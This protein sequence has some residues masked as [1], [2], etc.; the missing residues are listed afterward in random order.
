[1]CPNL[2]TAG[3]R[4]TRTVPV[5]TGYLCVY[6]YSHATYINACI[7]SIHHTATHRTILH[8]ITPCHTP[9]PIRIPIP[10]PMPIP[11]QP[12]QIYDMP[13]H[14]MPCHSVPMPTPMPCFPYTHTYVY[15]PTHAFAVL[16]LTR[17]LRGSRGTQTPATQEQSLRPLCPRRGC[18][19]SFH[20]RR[21]QF[22]NC[23]VPEGAVA[24]VPWLLSPRNSQGRG[25]LW[26]RYVTSVCCSG[27]VLAIDFQYV[28][29]QLQ[30]GGPDCT[31]MRGTGR[32]QLVFTI[33]M[34]QAHLDKEVA[35]AELPFQTREERNPQIQVPQIL[36]PTTPL[37]PLT[38]T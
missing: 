6:T 7:P 26:L 33:E 19:V 4:C 23:T 11:Y 9:M 20:E 29:H 17:I 36:Q 1:M 12:R 15:T 25:F 18:R 24:T 22:A 16:T 37:S 34:Q 31:F 10:T 2:C 30:M 13:C 32:A 3:F 38:Q 5:C 28:D 35:N 27:L 8:H 14:A 21:H